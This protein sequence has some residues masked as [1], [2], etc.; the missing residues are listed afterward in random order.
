MWGHWNKTIM[1]C[2]IS[3]PQARL[4]AVVHIPEKPVGYT[5]VCCHG[6]RGSKEGGGRAV[7]LAERMA[8]LGF[9]VVRFAFTPL[10]CLSAQVAEIGAVVGWCRENHGSQIILLGRSMGGSAALAFAAQAGWLAGLCLWAA[11]WNLAET[12]RLALGE[13]YDR[14]SRGEELAVEDEYGKLRLTPRFIADFARHDAKAAIRALAGIPILFVHGQADRIVPVKQAEELFAAASEPKELVI[15]PGGDH[16]FL[17]GHEQA[18]GAVLGWLT[19]NYGG[20]GRD[21]PLP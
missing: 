8:G 7:K 16:Q 13:G 1:E 2:D 17:A 21:L 14:L 5:V 12:F 18:S 10:T 3:G 6:F 20:D 15:I 19:R 4:P 11:P 9:A